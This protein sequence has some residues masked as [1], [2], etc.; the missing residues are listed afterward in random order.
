MA[1]AALVHCATRR[2]SAA[3]QAARPGARANNLLRNACF[4]DDWL[5]LLPQPQTLHW[6]YANGFYNRRDF[7]PD[8]WSCT[9]NWQWADADRPKGERRLILGA[10]VAQVMQ[11]VQW[12]AVHDDQRVMDF[13]DAGGFPQLHPLSSPRPERLVRDLTLRVR[14]KGHGVPADAGSIQLGLCPLGQATMGNALGSVV[15]PR[16]SRTI[17]FPT[18][19]FDWT[20]LE[21]RLPA[22]AWLQAAAKSAAAGALGGGQPLPQIVSATIR[23]E[24]RTGRIEVGAAELTEAEPHRPNLLPNGDFRSVDSAGYPAGWAQPTKYRYFPPGYYYLF[25]TWHNA[26]FENRGVVA[27]DRLISVAGGPSL[28]MIVP[29]G[30]EV[31]VA[32]PSI[33][34][35]QREARLIDV[36]VRV[37]TDRLCMLAIDAL[38]QNGARLDGFHFMHK[39]PVSIGTDGWRRLR[40]IF[41]PRTPI[42]SLRLRLCARGVNGYT[43]DATGLQ[44]QNNVVGTVWWDDVR[45]LE[46]ESTPEELA[47]RGVKPVPESTADVRPYLDDLDLGEQLFGAN[48][49][50]GR[51]VNRGPAAKFALEW[52]FTASGGTPAE[53][54]SESVLVPADGHE[55][56]RLPYTLDEPCRAAYTEYRGRLT[57]LRDGQKLD[58]TDLWF[59]TW[60]TPIDVKLG[61]LYL[62]PG[63]AQL[64]RLNL[65]FSAQTM[66]ELGALRLEVVRRGSGR[67]VHTVELPVTPKTIA[68]QRDR[69]PMDL[70]GDLTNLVLADL[71]VS[72]LP[73]QP[74][75]EPQRN[76][77]VRVTALDRSGRSIA[78]VESEA[79]CRQA[80]AP[81]QP[82]IRRVTVG[83]DNFL[84]INGEPWMPWGATYGF[85][86]AYA[87]AAVPRGKPYRDLHALPE[88]SMYDQ[89][90][91]DHYSR[92]END[93]NCARDV[94]GKVTS[95]DD[96]QARWTADNRY[97]S[98]AFVVPY[99]V[100]SPI[101]LAKQAGGQGALAT[102]LDFCKRAPMVV[103]TA[104]GIEEGFGVF[105]AATADQLAGLGQIVEHLRRATDKPVMV[106]HGGYW[107]RFELEKVPYFDIY[108][109]ET[110]PFYPAN[111]HTDLRPLIGGQSKVI[112]LRPQMYEDVPY[113]RWRFHVYT[114]LMRGCRGWQIAHGPGD[115]SL[116]R[117]LHGE[118]EFM[119]PIVASSDRGPKIRIDPWMEHWSRRYE[120]KTYLIAATTHGIAFG[121][122]RDGERSERAG[123]ARITETAVEHRDEAD[124]YGVRGAPLRGYAAHG[125]QYLPAARSWRRGSRLTQWIRLDKDGPPPGFAIVV[126]ADG[127]FIHAASWGRFDTAALRRDRDL[128]LWFLRTFYRHAVGFLGW[129]TKLLPAA[130][131]YVPDRAIDVGPPPPSGQWTRLEVPLDALGVTG[132]LVDGA[133]FLHAGGRIEWGRTSLIGP[134]GDEL[135]VWGDA[136]A[137]APDRVARTKIMVEGLK[138]GTR[139]R[140]L[141]E[142]RELAAAAGYFLDDFRGR[143]LYQ[144]FGGG[145]MVGYGDAP[146]AMHVYEIESHV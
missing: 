145:P 111:L 124:A 73:V 75:N 57:L 96:I 6:A 68:A 77:V 97:T 110:E 106:G 100:F 20:W 137:L 67:L 121:H 139:V 142:D 136:V 125:V 3:E 37:K 15:A 146:V 83:R 59:S 30:D 36:A 44:P 25:N 134:G 92:R 65:G 48:V 17:D 14:I 95:R 107:N 29:S 130:L 47:A 33:P 56:I 28:K 19:T 88:W 104:P 132:K 109:P 5:T 9:G 60:A 120:G 99:P 18:G 42:T 61:A 94:A 55:M 51:V 116:V 62:R 144:R 119:R 76:W 35:N 123:R 74:F 114:E 84:R 58:G 4:Q 53:F 64:V 22:A 54:V 38:D 2:A 117:G 50:A 141:F 122:W 32:S 85:A 70:R 118:L 82:A 46:P 34:L 115:A 43:L 86:P 40:Q 24:A 143:D 103:A 78:S 101:E 105:H 8:G 23:F 63:Q 112:W 126:K 138:P 66:A 72:A 128:A 49:L 89:F 31:A 140:V 98:T 16:A 27:L 21:V 71:D 26:L 91:A 45:V 81:P 7:N 39:A 10:P 80:H 113:E 129:D 108:D 93:F 79:F 41:R 52:T 69:L 133:G 131:G 135:E 13:P 102:Y 127:R 87:G 11:R 12:F 1:A 90:T